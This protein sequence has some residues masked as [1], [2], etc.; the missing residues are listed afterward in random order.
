MQRWN[1]QIRPIEFT[2]LDKQAHKMIIAWLLG[3]IEE[4]VFQ[5]K[6]DWVYLVEGGLFEYLQRMVLTDIKPPVFH[7]LVENREI[8]NKLD[9]YV[10]AKMRQDL[11]SLPGNFFE[12]FR[13]YLFEE[14]PRY[15]Q[16]IIRAAHYFATHWEFQIIDSA[17]PR[18][19]GL[20]ETKHAIE[21]EIVHYYEIEC[22]KQMV[23]Y[24]D[25]VDLCGQ[26]R[27]QRRWGQSERIPR[28]SVLGHML[29]VAML[30]YFSLLQWS[31]CPKR[32][33][34]DF[35]A[36]LFHDLPEV[37]TRDIISPV[38]RAMGELERVLKDYEEAQLQEKILPLLPPFC[39]DEITLFSRG[40]FENS[41]QVEGRLVREAD[42]PSIVS[43]GIITP[44]FNK[45]PYSPLD[46]V[47]L[48]ICDDLA[49]YVEASLSISYGIRSEQLEEGR[50]H[51]YDKYRHASI[52]GVELSQLFEG[53]WNEAER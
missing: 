51:L 32:V 5:K 17:S 53:F 45:D 49:A 14:K 24:R 19:Y 50:R 31:P 8:K 47:L 2:E 15:E 16:R 23:Q 39:A 13:E 48:K 41:L 22:V 11:S 27:F 21:S 18:L 34:N 37:L 12:R 6:V 43:D 42:N 20:D 44:V 46:G 1:D 36:G 52:G 35:F 28:T 33:Y 26:L 30:G 4:E 10:L 29:L 7:K 25:F 9:V 3:R 40:G 38:K